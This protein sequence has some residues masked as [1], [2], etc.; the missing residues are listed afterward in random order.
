MQV[1]KTK[2]EL[3]DITHLFYLFNTCVTVECFEIHF[4]DQ[5][6]TSLLQ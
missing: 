5:K 6:H 1:K 2:I 3:C 4:N